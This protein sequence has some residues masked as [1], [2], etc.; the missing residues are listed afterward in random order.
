M[1]PEFIVHTT[2]I[3]NRKQISATTFKFRRFDATRENAIHELVDD[4]LVLLSL[5]EVRLGIGA[6]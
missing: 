1:T 2:R 6:L 3:A 5:L 4:G